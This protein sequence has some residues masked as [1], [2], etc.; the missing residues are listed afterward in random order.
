MRKTLIKLQDKIDS[1][2]EKVDCN[3]TKSFAVST[4]NDVKGS[5]VKVTPD[6]GIN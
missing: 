4:A 2:E 6:A 5:F 3:A 1:I